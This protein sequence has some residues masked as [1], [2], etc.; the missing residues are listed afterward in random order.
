MSPRQIQ[1][2][3]A[4]VALVLI[5]LAATATAPGE[6]LAEASAETTTARAGCPGVGP[7]PVRTGSASA[8]RYRLASTAR[9]AARAR[10]ASRGTSAR[11]RRALARRLIARRAAVRRARARRALAIRPSYAEEWRP[12]R[13][14]HTAVLVIRG[15]GWRAVGPVRVQSM[16]P[17]AEHF[18]RNGHRALSLGYRSGMQGLLDVLFHHDLLR[19]RIGPETPICAYGE[20]AGGHFALMLA[21]VRDIECVSAVAAPL[22]LTRYP[23]SSTVRRAARE[24]FGE[25]R[26]AQL[27][28]LQRT[29]ELRARAMLVLG[30]GDRYINPDHA[31]EF[32]SQVPGTRVVHVASGDEPW[33][34]GSADA[35]SLR[36]YRLA[37]LAFLRGEPPPETDPE[38]DRPPPSDEDRPEFPIPF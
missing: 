16:R 7:I 3:I 15:G 38:S 28:P 10:K 34:H 36:R 33:V 27:S 4:S 8:A 37:E 25:E 18:A 23:S 9:A 1:P 35:D 30:E 31:H 2:L 19:L 17:V 20:S 13:P 26:L 5:V 6:R 22:D 14:A 32:A 21:L 12:C 24:A 11:T 29:S